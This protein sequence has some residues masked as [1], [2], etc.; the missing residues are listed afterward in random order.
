[1]KITGLTFFIGEAIFLMQ[2]LQAQIAEV[3]AAWN[4]VTKDVF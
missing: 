2:Q 4:Q 1:M 3:K